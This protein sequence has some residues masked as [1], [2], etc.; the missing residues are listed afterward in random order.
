MFILS[1]KLKKFTK[2]I[3]YFDKY[4]YNLHYIY[5]EFNINFF[6]MNLYS[7]S[8]YDTGF[9]SKNLIHILWA[10]LNLSC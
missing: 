6:K 5:R 4:K 7:I 9:N 3:K 8:K 10:M 1:K 2:D